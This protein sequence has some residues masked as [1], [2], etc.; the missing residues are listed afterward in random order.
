M[1]QHATELGQ[2]AGADEDIH[3]RAASTLRAIGA[4]V[5]ELRMQ[6]G[7]TLQAVSDLTG[8]SPSLMS[9]VERGKTSPSI[10]TL[11]AVAHA[12]EVHMADL[13]PGSNDDRESPVVRSAEQP[14]FSTP[15]GVTRR[16]LRDDRVRGVEIAVNEYSPGGRSA[17]RELHH[18][19]YEYG[20]VLDGSLVIEIEGE[21]HV[22]VPG[23]SIAYDST[24]SHRIVNE[25][26]A[27]VRTVWVNL[28]RN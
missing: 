22:L 12:L 27:P 4:R 21:S 7:L 24:R 20:Y 13:V 6:R 8:L 16:V 26:E 14:V 9:L 3:D 23:D 28:D 15:E 10:G 19:G 2:P 1:G 5:R 25:S 11:V 17:E 18:A